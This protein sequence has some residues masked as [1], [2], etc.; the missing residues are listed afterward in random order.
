MRLSIMHA[1]IQRNDPMKLRRILLPLFLTCSLL[2][3][4]CGDEGTGTNE[5]TV[6]FEIHL[7]AL[8]EDDLVKIEIDDREIFH[9]RVTTLAVLGVAEQI[10]LRMSPGAHNIRATVNGKA[11]AED[12]FQLQSDLYIL[13]GYH[14]GPGVTIN[15]TYEPPG[16]D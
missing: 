1:H 7:G 9:D 16:Y 11:H 13:V 5:A 15:F 3:V 8:F 10:K 14:S 4:S 6:P 12:S 2:A